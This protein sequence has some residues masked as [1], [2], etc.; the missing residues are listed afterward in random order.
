MFG[1]RFSSAG[2]SVALALVVATSV[3]LAM[4]SLIAV[5]RI[6]TTAVLVVATGACRFALNHAQTIRMNVHSREEGRQNGQGCV[7]MVL[8]SIF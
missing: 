3:L 1:R 5:A 7:F 8:S 2:G 4:M 6:E